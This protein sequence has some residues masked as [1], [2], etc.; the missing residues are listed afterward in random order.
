MPVSLTLAIDCSVGGIDT[1]KYTNQN[2][3]PS[4]LLRV[5]YV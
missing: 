2:K 5:L 4:E 3:N 1:K